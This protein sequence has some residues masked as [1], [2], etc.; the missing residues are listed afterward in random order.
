[1][2][3]SL[4]LSDRLPAPLAFGERKSVLIVEDEESIRDALVE[5]FDGAASVVG[6]AT[7]DEAIAALRA[8]PFDLVVTDVRL[9]TKR[10]AGFQV[11]AVAALLS[12]DAVVVTLTAYPNADARAASE[13]LGAARFLTKPVDL[14]A[15]AAIA[16]EAGVP[17]AVDGATSSA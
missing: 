15:L 11:M 16:R 9:G 6:A 5:L 14:C 2:R 1:M 12:P 17:T 3:S 7:L 8:R 4:A 13:R 10:D